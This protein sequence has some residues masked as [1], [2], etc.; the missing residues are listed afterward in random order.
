METTTVTTPVTPTTPPTTSTVVHQDDVCTVYEDGDDHYMVLIH[1]APPKEPAPVPT[2]EMEEERLKRELDQAVEGL[3]MV[4]KIYQE[5]ETVV[6][7]A[8]S[9]WLGASVKRMK[10]NEVQEEE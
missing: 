7:E 9:K 3:K 8:R 5:M 4:R 2:A 6:N 10:L 1:T